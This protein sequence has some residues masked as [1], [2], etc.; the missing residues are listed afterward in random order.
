[1]GKMYLTVEEPHVGIVQNGSVLVLF[2]GEIDVFVL[3]W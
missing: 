3:G 1:M 2:P